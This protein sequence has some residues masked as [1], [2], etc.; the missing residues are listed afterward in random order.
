LA[1][2][3]HDLDD[4]LRSGMITPNQLDGIALWEIITRASVG[5][6]VKLWI[7]FP[8]TDYPPLD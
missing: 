6:A 8:A 1:Y 5:D 4:G 3:S 2:T 7:P